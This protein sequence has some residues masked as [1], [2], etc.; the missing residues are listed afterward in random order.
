[1]SASGSDLPLVKPSGKLRCRSGRS[2]I[3]N[4]RLKSSLSRAEAQ[5]TQCESSSLVDEFVVCARSRSWL[6]GIGAVLLL[7]CVFSWNHH[8]MHRYT[9]GE[10]ASSQRY[11]AIRPCYTSDCPHDLRRYQIQKEDMSKRI[12]ALQRQL[13]SSQSSAM[14]AQFAHEE[15]KV[16][17]RGLYHGSMVVMV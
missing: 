15:Y 9:F 17:S 14:Q 11:R 10:C 6:S 8:V 5:S 12:A 4:N 1:M 16:S 3:D 7:I 2:A 13:S